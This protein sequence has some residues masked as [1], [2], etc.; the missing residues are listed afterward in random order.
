DILKDISFAVKPGQRIAI[1]GPTAAGKTQL[2]Y[3]LIGLLPPTS[4]TIEYD[5]RTIDQYQPLSLRRQVGLVFQDSSLFNASLR[6]NI[7]FS[8]DDQA[9]SQEQLNKAI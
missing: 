6:Q 4:G 3:T 5:G 9:I 8:N 1:I 2:L 7:A